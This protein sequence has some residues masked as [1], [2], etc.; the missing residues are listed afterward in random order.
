V[1]VLLKLH[2]DACVT[3][4]IVARLET[5][6]LRTVGHLARVG[7]PALRRQFG[8]VGGVLAAAA[9][10]RD[11][12]PLQPTPPPD[13]TSARL[14]MGSGA[15]P[16]RVLAALAPFA[17]QVAARLRQ[18]GRRAGTLRLGLRWECG[19]TQG[20]RLSLRQPTDDPMV[21]AQEVLRLL[22]PLLRTHAV[23]AEG[24]AAHS[25]TLDGLVLALGDFVPVLPAQA[26][27]WRTRAQRLA[28]AGSTAEALARRHGRPLLLQLEAARPDAIFEEE[29]YL[30]RVLSAAGSAR[31]TRRGRVAA[32]SS[33]ALA[34]PW[35]AVPQRLHWW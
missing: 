7:E 3:P 28:A 19:C 23:C 27:F 2:A 20:A 9:T 1:G 16:D 8:P 10:G 26:T 18:Q 33:A 5:Y 25:Q 13:V 34:D 14:R 17:R 24:E 22:L 11:V 4:E 6:G 29:R 21:L 15:P 30:A 32:R 12:R 35:S 31:A